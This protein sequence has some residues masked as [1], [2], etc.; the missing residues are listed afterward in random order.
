VSFPVRVKEK[1]LKGG[2]MSQGGGG[3]G[4]NCEK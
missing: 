3:E 1:K 4:G 2:E